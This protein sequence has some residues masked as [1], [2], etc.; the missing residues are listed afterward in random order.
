MASPLTD[1]VL[2]QLRALA[3]QATTVVDLEAGLRLLAK[4]R[5]HVLQNTLVKTNGVRVLAGPFAGMDYLPAAIEGCHIPRL[6]GCYEQPL[7]PAVE[8]AI[9]RQ[10][11]LIINIGC[12]E[13]YYAVGMARRLPQSRVLAFD[14]NVKARVACAELARRNGVEARLEVGALF[15]PEDFARYAGQNALLICDIEGAEKDLLDPN[16]APALRS[17]DLI[18]EAHNGINS[19]ISALLAQRFGASHKVQIVEDLGERKVET[20][21]AWFGEL[22]HLDQLLAVWEWRATP[23]PWLIMTQ[24]HK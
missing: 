18:V 8:A 13:G 7:H 24:R 20:P 19:G 12:A 4:W 5:S 15:K 11:P 2:Q 21:P 14:I 10:P 16:R 3:A 6:L 22:G 17:M 1:T 9:A 23:T